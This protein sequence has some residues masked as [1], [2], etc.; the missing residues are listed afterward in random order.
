MEAHP[1]GTGANPDRTMGV[2]TMKPPRPVLHIICQAHLDPVWLWTWRDGFAE[3]LTTLQSAVDRLRE[4]PDLRYTC[5]AAYAYR[6]VKETDPRLFRDIRTFIEEGRWEVVGGW[7][8]QADTLHPSEFSLRR[9]GVL[10]QDWFREN[11]GVTATVGYCV[12]S[13]GHSAGLPSILAGA[14]LRY[15]VFQ[16]PQPHEKPDLPNLF[17]W[18]APNG[19]RVLTWRLAHGYGQ[20]PGCTGDALE[21][22]L[23]TN[24]RGLLAPDMPV[25]TW[26]V[27]IGNHGG[28]PTRVQLDHICRL[29]TAKDPQLPELR[30]S[31]LAEFFAEVER[32]PAFAEVPV[33][34]GELLH[35]ARGC[36]AANTRIKRLHRQAER[37]LRTAENLQRMRNGEP[38]VPSEP[39][40]PPPEDLRE[41]WWTLCFNQFH[42]ILPGSSVPSAYAEVRDDLGAARHAARRLSVAAVH[43]LAR[44]ADT[45]GAPEG[46]LFLANPL[47]WARTALVQ[48][49]AFVSPHGDSPITHLASPDGQC[50]PL[51][52]AAADAG[53]GPFLKE[54]RKLVAAVPMPGSGARWFHL[55]HG[56]VPAFPTPAP[57]ALAALADS[58]RLVVVEDRADTWGHGVD[59][60][61]DERGWAETA[62]EKLLDDGPVFRRRRRWLTWGAS[63]VALDI[64]EWHPLDAVELVLHIN[65]QDRYQALKLELPLPTSAAR[66]EVR[67]PGAVVDRPLDGDE[68]FWGDWLSL[69]EGDQR[70]LLVSDGVAAYAATPE[71]LRLTLLRCVP[72]AQHAPVPHPEDSPAPF[73]DEGYQEARFWLTT[74][75]AAA[76]PEA[77]DR[78]AAG[79]LTPAEQM[80]DSAHRGALA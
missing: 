55:A 34:R 72:H 9:Q 67:T 39:M 13:F 80:L 36:Y 47:S 25:G 45:Q 56:E 26:F 64:V 29:R 31:T 20:G 35:H 77:L 5:S 1:A 24:W 33:I 63:A 18:E 50:L 75:D 10:A 11:L 17:W 40:V 38:P 12:D 74:A 14:G 6:W 44:R 79:F 37:D 65:W 32:Q 70:L 21:K 60:W 7:V 68:W 76:T 62:R 54:W 41:A 58:A 27:G 53:F 2:P 61:S 3:V 73:L 48:L 69:A 46:V 78:L 15:Y 19:A 43:S 52:W 16:R 30:F 49:D 4:F 8:V 23:R 71:R 22:G 28:G 42:D 51:Q 57:G 66:L 59:R